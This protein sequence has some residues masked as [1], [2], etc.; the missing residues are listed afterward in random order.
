MYIALPEEINHDH[1]FSV[2]LFL[3]IFIF[4]KFI[5]IDSLFL[6]IPMPNKLIYF[7]SFVFY[8]ILIKFV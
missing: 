7:F 3:S 2:I 4:F 1:T 8:V 6:Q 5:L